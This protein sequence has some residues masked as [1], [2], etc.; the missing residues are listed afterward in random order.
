MLKVGASLFAVGF[1]T[2][3]LGPTF[4]AGA[5]TTLG[6]IAQAT[7]AG[8]CLLL[9]VGIGLLCK[10]RVAVFSITGA[11]LGAVSGAVLGLSLDATT[12]A[13]GLVPGAFLFGLAGVFVAELS[14][15]ESIFKVLAGFLA[16]GVL[17][18]AIIAA[19]WTVIGPLLI[20]AIKYRRPIDMAAV[21]AA[22]FGFILATRSLVRWLFK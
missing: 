5:T 2:M 21:L 20:S 9:L 10:S 11:I 22:G 18:A 7:T 6:R 8:G 17:G 4:G 3:M 12:G 19:G 13:I 16:M 1:L 14:K 15:T